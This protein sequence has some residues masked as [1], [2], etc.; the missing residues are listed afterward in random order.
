MGTPPPS[1][2]YV[3]STVSKVRTMTRQQQVIAAQYSEGAPKTMA[4]VQGMCNE[5]W[6]GRSTI[7]WIEGDRKHVA[8]TF[9]RNRIEGSAHTWLEAM[10]AVDYT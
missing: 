4:R 3:N 8:V 6:P 1:P 10:D 9:K 7:Q 5:R 2:A